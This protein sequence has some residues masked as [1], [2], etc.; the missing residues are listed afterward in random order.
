MQVIGTIQQNNNLWHQAIKFNLSPT[1]KFTKRFYSKSSEILNEK[2]KEEF[3]YSSD[4]SPSNSI[5]K[6]GNYHNKFS[7]NKDRNNFLLMMDTKYKKSV[8]ESLALSEVEIYNITKE[9]D[10]RHKKWTEIIWNIFSVF[11]N[12]KLKEINL[13]FDTNNEYS[14]GYA[15]I[16]CLAIEN[17]TEFSAT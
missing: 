3:D 4:N 13:N 17:F 16:H 10:V 1:D 9:Y 12:M 11:F 15:C 7:D 6:S 14:E 5:V 8:G 2:E